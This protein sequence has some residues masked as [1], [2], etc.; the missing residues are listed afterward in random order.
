MGGMK[1]TAAASFLLFCAF[2]ALS[3]C[4]PDVPGIIDAITGQDK[5]VPVLE[6]MEMLDRKVC[7]LT[8]SESVLVTEARLDGEEVEARRPSAAEVDIV[9]PGPL[10]IGEPTPLFLRVR[11][12]AWNSSAFSLTVTGRNMDLPGFKLNEVSLRGS[13]TQ[14]QRIEL[15]VT[16]AG[17]VEGLCVQDGTRGNEKHAYVLPPIDVGTGDYIVIY[18]TDTPSEDT[19]EKADGT[20]VHH[21]AAQSGES[22]PG[23]NG[24]V[25]VYDTVSGDGEVL[26]CLVYSS[27]DASTNGG[28]GSAAVEDSYKKLTAS[29]DWIGDPVPSTWATTTRTLARKPGQDTNS[30][31]DF[32]TTVTRGQTFGSMNTS[33][34][35]E[36][37]T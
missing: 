24:V 2:L 9:A 30:A 13:D 20:F 37:S 33:L 4:S 14:P 32:Y 17:N 35:Y 3:A 28:F 31:R 10:A 11:D 26:D 21:L 1:T 8:F 36:G 5:L 23:R 25:C 27:G 22:L 19:E 16:S 6:K 7:R 29:F 15:E 12:H 34:E 18:W